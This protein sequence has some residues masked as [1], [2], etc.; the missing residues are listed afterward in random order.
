M[1]VQSGAS[2]MA[3]SRTSSIYAESATI[4]TSTTFKSGAMGP[5]VAFGLR[6]W[7]NMT[8][9]AGFS[10]TKRTAD[11]SIGGSV[12]SPIFF[13]RPRTLAGTETALG[14]LPGGATNILVRAL[15]LPL[16]P[17]EA[18]A[19]LHDLA[20]L[21]RKNLDRPL[22]VAC[23]TALA[24]LREGGE[25]LRWEPMFFDWFG[26]EASPEYLDY[27]AALSKREM[28]RWMGGSHLLQS[29]PASTATWVTS[30]RTCTHIRY[31]PTAF[32]WRSLPRRRSIRSASAA[33]RGR[34]RRRRRSSVPRARP[35]P[36]RF[37]TPFHTS[38]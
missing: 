26:G 13:N 29:L 12:P 23:K 6:V 33:I 35:A 31:R 10:Q 27:K 3:D 28:D 30:S 14:A 37:T 16:D 11:G 2:T 32:P 8:V 7:H 18:A 21:W 38:R 5:D 24:L 25:G 19:M 1:A 4:T 17:V 9:G 20:D 36:T 15:D 34:A 22:G